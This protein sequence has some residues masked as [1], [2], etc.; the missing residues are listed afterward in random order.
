MGEHDPN[1][2]LERWAERVIDRDLDGLLALYDRSAVLIPTFSN[3]LLC[4]HER[5]RE[6]FERLCSREDLRISLHERPRVAT[7]IDGGLQA[8]AGIYRWRFAVD[9]EPLAFEA[10][11]SFLLDLARPSPIL[12]HH[13][14]QIPR[15]L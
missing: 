11:F 2:F 12:H 8:L 4:G 7:A 14:S 10:R 15:T 5:I 9:G 3:R 1:R 13:S 6:Y